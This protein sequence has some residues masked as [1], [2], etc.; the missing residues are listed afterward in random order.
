M[1]DLKKEVI[2]I[3]ES[4]RLNQDIIGFF[5]REFD[6]ILTDLAQVKSTLVGPH[7]TVGVPTQG[8]NILSSTSEVGGL[9]D[10]ERDR[11][12]INHEN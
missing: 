2:H 5:Q 7:E 9:M 4:L 11:S 1:S 10:L 12:I 8:S 3:R 6:S